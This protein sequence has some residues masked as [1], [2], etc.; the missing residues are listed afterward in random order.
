MDGIDKKRFTK[1]G[2]SFELP[3]DNILVTLMGFITNHGGKNKRGIMKNSR[4]SPVVFFSLFFSLL[5]FLIKEKLE[6][7]VILRFNGKVRYQHIES[8]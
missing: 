6:F 4:H 3:G 1:K 8:S 2:G 7:E 5:I